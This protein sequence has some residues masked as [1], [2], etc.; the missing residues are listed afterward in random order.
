MAPHVTASAQLSYAPTWLPGGLASLEWQKVGSYWM[1]DANTVQY[2]GH[3]LV[4]L[5]A[6]VQVVP[7]VKVFGRIMNLLNTRWAT[8]AS[9]SGN[10]PQYA[11]GLPLNA[12]GGVVVSF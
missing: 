4:N 2:G 12:Y 1:N 7:G 11:P 5:R 6:E 3:D 8:S 9:T 10:T